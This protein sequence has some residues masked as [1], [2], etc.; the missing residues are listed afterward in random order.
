VA[1][2][3]SDKAAESL[4]AAGGE[5]R[6]GD[7]NDVEVLK[8]GAASTDG[9]AHLGFIHDFANFEASCKTDRKAVEAFLSVL[10][11]TSKPIVASFGTLAL[12]NDHT[13]TEDDFQ[14]KA[15][16]GALRVAT[17]EILL[18]AGKED[19]VQSMALRLAP[20]VHGKGDKAFIAA[21]I[22]AAKRNSKSPFIGTGKTRWPAVHRLDAARLYVA[23]LE[24]PHSGR[25]LHAIGEEGVAFKEIASTIGKH[26]DVPVE[27]IS[28]GEA[29][30]KH[31]GFLGHLV[32]LDNPVSSAATQ[33]LLHW[34]PVEVGL[35][36]DL[37]QGHY[38]EQGA[39]SILSGT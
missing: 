36:A 21:I 33:E 38:F 34:K 15:G 31:F 11:G 27:S 37:D 18:R 20:T 23:A 4:R 32:G 2:A 14:P 12:P 7:L 17:E 24:R 5:V 3:R 6:R 19:G 30:S 13:A 16:F 26:L 22:D 25:V 8:E 35:L 29:A 9:V 39:G 1:L 28:A 10:K